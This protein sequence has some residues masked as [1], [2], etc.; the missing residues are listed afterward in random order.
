MTN[1]VARAGL[2]SDFIAQNGWKEADVCPLKSDASFR[3]YTRLSRGQE[4][5]MVMDA[6]PD[7]EDVRPYLAITRHLSGSGYSAPHIYAEDIEKGLLLIE[8]LGDAIYTQMIAH[9]KAQEAPLYHAAVDVLAAWLHDKNM[10]K[11]TSPLS[12]PDYAHKEYMREVCLL[13]EW[14]LPQVLSG[15]VLAVAQ[16]EYRGIWEEILSAA[17]LASTLFVH[18]DYHAD[19]LL[20][21]P[22]RA[23]V[24]QV[25]LLDF[26][27]ALWGHPAYDLASLL[28]DARRDVAPE[29]AEECLQRYVRAAGVEDKAFR[30]SYALLA[31]QRNCKIVGIFWRLTQRDGKPHYLNYL[32]RVWGHV[33]HDLQAPELA[34]LSAWMERYVPQA[35]RGSKAA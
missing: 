6:P 3:H 11:S 27:D 14:F 21:L 4:S 18:R 9:G 5:A 13:S 34:R 24:K 2:I 28:E 26:Q 7:K 20:W 25:G 29:F 35:S 1:A 15:E 16:A 30:A 12:I 17:N 22:D 19:N 32:P 33:Q 31:A 23:G 10:Q 8:D